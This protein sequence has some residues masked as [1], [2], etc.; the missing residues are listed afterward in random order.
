[1]T[2]N[3]SVTRPVDLSRCTRTSLM[4]TEFLAMSVNSALDPAVAW[5]N[6][7]EWTNSLPMLVISPPRTIKLLDDEEDTPWGEFL[8]VVAAAKSML[9]RSVELFVEVEGV[10]ERNLSADRSR[11]DAYEVTLL[12]TT[13]M[14]F[15][16]RFRTMHSRTNGVALF[17]ALIT[18][19]AFTGYTHVSLST[20]LL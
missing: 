18:V 7:T 20:F 2:S 19:N 11:P 8:L 5:L 17:T 10:A 1:M 15:S 13:S 14:R 4:A 16:R 9:V 3:K 12:S 6:W